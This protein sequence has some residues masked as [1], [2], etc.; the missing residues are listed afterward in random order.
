MATAPA[1]L[2]PKALD[3]AG[4]MLGYAPPSTGSGGLPLAPS[5]LGSGVKNLRGVVV[6]DN[7]PK[8]VP[9]SPPRPALLSDQHLIDHTARAMTVFSDKFN[10]GGLQKVGGDAVKDTVA[11]ISNGARWLWQGPGREKTPYS[12]GPD[13]ATPAKPQAQPAAP[14]NSAAAIPAA[15][16]GQP[17][18][19]QPVQPAAPT[20]PAAPTLDSRGSPLKPGM[21]EYAPGIFVPE[22]G[23]IARDARPVLGMTVNPDGS[24]LSEVREANADHEMVSNARAIKTLSPLRPGASGSLTGLPNTQG[25]TISEGMDVGSRGNHY[26]G[27][28][29]NGGVTGGN[30]DRA[31]HLQRNREDIANSGWL[32]MNPDERKRMEQQERFASAERAGQRSEDIAKYVSDQRKDAAAQGGGAG[33]AKMA[34]YHEQMAKQAQQAGDDAGAKWH[35]EQM[36]KFVERGIGTGVDKDGK[37]LPPREVTQQEYNDFSAMIRNTAFPVNPQQQQQHAGNQ[38]RAW[39]NIGPEGQAQAMADPDTAAKLR[40]SAQVAMNFALQLPPDQY[41]RFMATPGMGWAQQILN[42]GKE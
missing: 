6:P 5:S 24:N 30:S 3:R 9:V 22:Q 12:I 10:E 33:G 2:R 35:M 1:P 21:R 27:M 15:G 38:L 8:A 31:D 25:F 20:A 17:D 14:A 37:A 23:P 26:R 19:T 42:Y 34:Q 16:E 29:P 18:P 28:D 7:A 41:K 36:G 32:R 40:Q 4:K 39:A 11:A 13:S